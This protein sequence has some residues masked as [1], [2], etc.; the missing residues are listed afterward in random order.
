MKSS[1][2]DTVVTMNEKLKDIWAKIVTVCSEVLSQQNRYK[3]YL[4]YGKSQ[5]ES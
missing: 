4:H 2:Q 5:C 3:G 1:G